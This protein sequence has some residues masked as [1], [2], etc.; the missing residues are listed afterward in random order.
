MN[1][2]NIRTDPVMNFHDQMGYVILSA[3]KDLRP[4]RVRSFAALRMTLDGQPLKE[5]VVR[6][7]L[8]LTPIELA[9][10]SGIPGGREAIA[11]AIRGVVSNA[12]V[13][14]LLYKSPPQ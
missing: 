8:Q 3:A 5:V 7:R 12:K 11:W 9:K 2:T 1:A 13:Q 6:S 4:R 10:C 14:A